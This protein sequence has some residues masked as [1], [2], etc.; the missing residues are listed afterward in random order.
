MSPSLA[1]FVL[2]VVPPISVLAV[3]YGRYLRKLSKA[4]QDSLAEATQVL[5]F[6]VCDLGVGL[7]ATG[8]MHG[9]QGM[10]LPS[11]STRERNEQLSPSLSPSGR[12]DSETV[13][14]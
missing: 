9:V 6:H 3:I 12:Q 14:T 11:L 2:S 10:F 1:T 13:Y 4:T 5:S 7:R 8:G